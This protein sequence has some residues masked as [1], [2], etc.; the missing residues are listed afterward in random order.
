MRGLR[1]VLMAAL[2]LAASGCFTIEQTMTFERDLSGTAGVMMRVDLEPAVEFMAAMAR[3]MSGQPGA[4]TEA[5]LAAMR[6][7]MLASTSKSKPI[8]FEQEKTEIQGKLP[9]GVRLID[10]SFKDDG[11]RMT[12]SLRFG[13]DHASKLGQIKLDQMPGVATAAPVENPID[14]PFGGLQ[15]VDEGPTILVTSP[16]QNPAENQKAALEQMPPLDA[17]LKK[18]FDAVFKTFRVACRIT[19]PFEAIEHNAHRKDGNTL[20]WEYDLASVETLTPAQMSQGIRVR[21]RK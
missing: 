2:G 19:A 1:A 10:A 14:S 11:P 4:P 3:S 6:K 15:V 17:T 20:I 5:E 12:A 16:A 7:E 8:D 18:Y 9:A 21:Y 13:F